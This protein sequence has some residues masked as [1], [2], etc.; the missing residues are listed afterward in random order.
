MLT[1]F[2]T[3][4]LM[5]EQI[6]VLGKDDRFD[7]FDWLRNSNYLSS[8]VHA[9][10]RSEIHLPMDIDVLK[11]RDEIACFVMTSPRNRLARSAI[12]RTWGK[13]IKPLFIMGL[14][15][16]DTMRFVINEAKMFND[17]IIEDFV[18]SYINLTIKTAFAMKHFVRHFEN[19]KYFLKI[20]DDVLLNTKN[21][22]N[23]L[24]DENLMENAIIGARGTAVKPHRE[25]ESKWYIPHWLY[26]NESFPEY[27]DGPVYLIPGKL[28]NIHNSVFYLAN[29]PCLFSHFL[30]SFCSRV[31]IY[32]SH[33]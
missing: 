19:S 32:R 1:S 29:I 5:V 2:V 27:V 14:S 8:F 30:S 25:R 33:G 23:H 31:F 24:N 11:Q 7:L 20:D 18:D 12:R 6:V 26:G 4:Q 15:D 21:L 9:E 22:I 10:S 16:N 17:I 13:V 3:L 28:N